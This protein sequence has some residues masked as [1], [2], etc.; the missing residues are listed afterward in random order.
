MTD[1]KSPTSSNIDTAGVDKSA[2][3]VRRIPPE[4]TWKTA[5][6]QDGLTSLWESSDT[7]DL[8]KFES[9]L[10]PILQEM[11]KTVMTFLKDKHP[12]DHPHRNKTYADFYLG[13][14]VRWVVSDQLSEVTRRM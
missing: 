9:Q 3:P 10:K 13:T 7:P 1:N 8:S 14:R 5:G 12:G 2:T 4:I 11:A 6:Q